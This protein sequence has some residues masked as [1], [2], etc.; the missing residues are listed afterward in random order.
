MI[1]T[2]FQHPQ[3]IA[4]TSGFKCRKA[5]TFVEMSTH[6]QTVGSSQSEFFLCPHDLRSNQ[7]W[8]VSC[9]CF[10]KDKVCLAHHHHQSC[11]K[12]RSQAKKLQMNRAMK[13]CMKRR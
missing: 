10:E 6:S 9:L 13:L 8:Q 2:R 1:V 4:N 11:T 7:F 3:H 5:S 12:Q